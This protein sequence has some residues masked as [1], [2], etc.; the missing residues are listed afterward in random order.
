MNSTEKPFW[1]HLEELRDRIL[2]CLRVLVLTSGAGYVVRR[3]ILEF[4]K[5]PLLDALPPDKQHLYFTGLFES[6]FNHLQVAILAG[7]FIGSP[8]FLWQVWAF[9]GPGLRQN[10]RR[11]VIPFVFFGTLFFFAGAAFAYWLVLPYGF[12]FFVEFGAP[13]DVPMITVREYFSVLFR[14]LLLFGLSF[15][16]PVILVLLAHLGLVGA[17]ALRG[18]RRNALIAIAVFSA[19]FAPPDVASM[20]LMMAPLYAFYEIAI[21]AIAFIE[22]R[23]CA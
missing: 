15:E 19:L 22:K 5:K 3:P 6:F 16:M 2:R 13:Y 21:L 20:L 12:K 14:L 17:D 11:A 9:V 18:H 23:D 10:E 7:A 4:L 1:D 8:Y